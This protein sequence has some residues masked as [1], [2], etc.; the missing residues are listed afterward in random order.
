M[1]NTTLTSAVENFARL[2]LPLSEKDLDR[3]YVLVGALKVL[4]LDGAAQSFMPRLAAIKQNSQK[5]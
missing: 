4:E 1:F 5:S 3:L 2:M